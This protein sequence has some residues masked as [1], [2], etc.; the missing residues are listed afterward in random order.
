ME[1]LYEVTN[2]QL[3]MEKNNKNTKM[4]LEM[5]VKKSLSNNEIENGKTNSIANVT[6][7]TTHLKNHPYRL[8][9]QR[10]SYTNESGSTGTGVG[11]P[12]SFEE[13]VRM[14]KSQKGRELLMSESARAFRRIPSSP[15]LILGN[16][17]KKVDWIRKKPLVRDDNDIDDVHVSRNSFIKS[18][19]QTIKRAVK[20]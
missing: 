18:S 3:V 13:N 7:K 16:M 8:E 19:I 11:Q 20:I 10:R 6:N 14:G 2:Q 9:P 12:D 1:K 17:K 15:S 5:E 4:I